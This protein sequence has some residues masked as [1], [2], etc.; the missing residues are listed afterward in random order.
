MSALTAGLH[1]MVLVTVAAVPD[2]KYVLKKSIDVFTVKIT[3]N[4]IKKKKKI[5]KYW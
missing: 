2:H 5:S 1:M 3:W 4:I